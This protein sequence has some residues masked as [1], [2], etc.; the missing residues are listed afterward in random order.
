MTPTP[1]AAAPAPLPIDQATL[2][3]VAHGEHHAPHSV[4]GAHLDDRGVVT[5]RTVK[6]LAEAVTVILAD[7]ARIPLHHEGFGVW[8]GTYVSPDGAH[9]PDYRIEVAYENAEPVVVDEPYRYL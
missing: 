4:L 7:D 5:F 9:V 2:G 6:H 8:V 3:Q 1:E